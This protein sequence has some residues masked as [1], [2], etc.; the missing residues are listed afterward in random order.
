[1]HVIWIASSLFPIRLPITCPRPCSEIR[2]CLPDYGR[3]SILHA[4]VTVFKATYRCRLHRR[5]AKKNL[6]L[7]FI[8]RPNNCWTA[9]RVGIQKSLW[10][11]LI[12]LSPNSHG[13]AWGTGE[14]LKHVFIIWCEMRQML[15]HPSFIQHQVYLV[16][17]MHWQNTSSTDISPVCQITHFNPYGLF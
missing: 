15:H 16:D 6:T 1:M 17:I 12:S 10:G 5:N 13:A 9:E 3:L 4:P 7:L 14:H 2:V 11:T 8:Y